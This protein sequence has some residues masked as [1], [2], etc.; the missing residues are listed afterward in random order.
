MASS[1]PTPTKRCSGVSIFDV[2]VLVLRR[3]HS[4]CF[5]STWC[6][7]DEPNQLSLSVRR[8]HTDRGTCVDRAAPLPCL[9][10]QPC[11]S[12]HLFETRQ[13]GQNPD[14][15]RKSSH[16]HQAERWCRYPCNHYVISTYRT[17]A[18]KVII[19]LGHIYTVARQEYLISHKSIC[20]RAMSSWVMI[21][22]LG[23][24][25]SPGTAIASP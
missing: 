12:V 9:G 24:E 17:L 22:M 5:N 21:S 1:E 2:W 16:L 15:V 20:Q 14:L 10:D 3:L 18:V 7:S 11:H 8:P 19:T 23:Y 25:N 4:S 6:L 13:C